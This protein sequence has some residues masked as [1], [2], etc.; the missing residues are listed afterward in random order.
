MRSGLASKL[1]TGGSM[2]FSQPPE[3]LGY[4]FH[5]INLLF[6][7]T[8]LWPNRSDEQLGSI[9]GQLGTEKLGRDAAVRDE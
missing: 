7:T 8:F 9:A 1:V 2:T 5:L 4:C 6:A 3:L